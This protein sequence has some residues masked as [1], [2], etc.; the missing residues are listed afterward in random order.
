MVSWQM[1]KIYKQRQV[2]GQR[3]LSF[4]AVMAGSSLT[5]SE[6]FSFANALEELA[7]CAAASVFRS[8]SF[9][10]SEVLWAVAAAPGRVRATLDALANPLVEIA[11]RTAVRREVEAIRPAALR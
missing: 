5:L 4:K 7:L 1:E 10:L 8:L 9:R 2:P 3:P 6:A 11:G